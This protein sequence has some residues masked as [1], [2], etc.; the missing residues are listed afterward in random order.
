[1]DIAHFALLNI[2][3]YYD[4]LLFSLCLP[5]AMVRVLIYTDHETKCIVRVEVFNLSVVQV[6]P[7]I[8]LFHV[9]ESRVHH[10][11]LMRN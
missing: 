10:K 11:Q 5:D 3:K 9:T 6:D 2:F 7:C 1:M 8:H 4:Y